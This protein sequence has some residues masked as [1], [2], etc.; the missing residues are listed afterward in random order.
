M[1]LSFGT[2]VL[3]SSATIQSVPA[4]KLSFRGDGRILCDPGCPRSE[5]GGRMGG[6][7]MNPKASAQALLLGMAASN[8]YK[9]QQLL[10]H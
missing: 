4:K 8:C 7:S 3:D 1:A 6:H 10:I 5:V 2:A 9:N